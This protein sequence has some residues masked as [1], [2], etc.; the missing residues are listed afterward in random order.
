MYIFKD[1]LSGYL[2]KEAVE[3]LVADG[4]WHVLS[5]FNNGLST[6]LSVDGRLVLNSTGKSMDLTPVS[7]EK[8]VLGAARTGETRLQQSGDV[9]TYVSLSENILGC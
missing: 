9:T 1:A 8:I 2:S 4:V 3:P 6:F 7:V 5:L